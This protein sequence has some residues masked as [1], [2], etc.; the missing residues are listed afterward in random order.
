MSAKVGSGEVV[1]IIQTTK[2]PF[3][4]SVNLTVQSGKAVSF[5]LYLRLPIWCSKPEIKVNGQKLS[6]DVLAGGY[7]KITRNWKN[8]DKIVLQLPMELNVRKWAKNKNSVS[9]NYGPLTFSLKI[10]ENYVRRD[11]KE[12]AIG[13]SRWQEKADP[14]KWPS[15]EIYPSSAWNYG[16][17]LNKQ[18]PELSFTIV[19]K[20]WPTDNNPFTNSGAPIELKAKGKKITS[21]TID[22]YGLCSV[23]PQSP[24]Q[25]KEEVSNLTFVP[26][27]GARLRISAFPVVN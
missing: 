16:L 2:Y 10:N 13:D 22:Q 8:G 15:Y 26:M 14:E 3:E 19:K 6:I 7:V 21:W 17:L 25:T 18:K 12:T 1:S 5:P 9:V 20:P 24:V 27:G 11:S 4:E 23:L